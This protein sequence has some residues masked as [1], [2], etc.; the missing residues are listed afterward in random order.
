MNLLD[1]YVYEFQ[2]YLRY[3]GP[4]RNA[5]SLIIETRQD[6]FRTISDSSD[7]TTSLLELTKAARGAHRQRSLNGL[8]AK[9]RRVLEQ[10]SPS[11]FE[12]N[13][14]FPNAERQLVQKSIILKKSRKGE[15]GVL[16]VSFEDQW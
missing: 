11:D 12:W 15:K 6:F 4:F 1:R 16:F 8:E 10:W 13:R 14:F 7:A 2:T 3:S 5:A 9:I